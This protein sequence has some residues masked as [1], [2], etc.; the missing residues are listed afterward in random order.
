MSVDY[1]SEQMTNAMVLMSVILDPPSGECPYTL[2]LGAGCSISSGIPDANGLINSWRD[3]IKQSKDAYSALLKKTNNS[4]KK[5]ISSYCEFIEQ[6]KNELHCDSEYGALFEYTRKTKEQRQIY[7]EKLLNEIKPGPGYIYLAGLIKQ[8]VFNKILT[9]NFDDL[10]GD[11]L[12]KYYNLKPLSC[13]FDSA[14]S[15]I[16]YTSSRPKI[17]KLHGDYLYSNLKNTNKELQQLDKNMEQ[18]MVD[19]CEDRGMVVYGYAGNDS[20]IMDCLQTN[21]RNNPKFLSKGLHW[22][23]YN[24]GKKQVKISDELFKLKKHFPDRVFLYNAPS[25]DIF[26]SLLFDKANVSLPERIVS[27]HYNNCANDFYMACEMFEDGELASPPMCKHMEKALKSMSNTISTIE[28]NLRKVKLQWRKGANLR[29][30][31]RTYNKACDCF[32]KGIKLLDDIKLSFEKNNEIF[33]SS[34]INTEVCINELYHEY[35]GRS[36]SINVAMYKIRK[37][38]GKDDAL[39]YLNAAYEIGRSF[40]GSANNQV[41]SRSTQTIIYNTVCTCGL[42]VDSNVKSYDELQDLV[43]FCIQNLK[44]YPRRF[45]KLIRTDSDIK[46]IHN[47]IESILNEK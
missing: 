20:S 9:T 46:A 41:D 13:S 5:I 36:V 35:Q 43:Y 44:K 40:S 23:I 33:N 6:L 30:D 25:F 39:D 27:L 38:L 2:F 14:I 47:E 32:K 18:K 45:N 12:V 21:M 3:E 7:I 42:L 15:T 1:N 11:A 37:L 22:C 28:I 26:F 34:D 10:L 31:P 24:S 16:N 8:N 29:H 19:M 4:D 17:L